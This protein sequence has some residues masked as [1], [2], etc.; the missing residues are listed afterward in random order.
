MEITNIYD[1]R[2]QAINEAEMK[3]RIAKRRLFEAERELDEI[4]VL[5]EE[6]LDENN[7]G[8]KLN[9]IKYIHKNMFTVIKKD[10]K[11]DTNTITLHNKNSQQY[12]V[13]DM[14]GNATNKNCVEF[15]TKE[16]AEKWA[17]KMVK[18]KKLYDGKY[19]IV[20][21]EEVQQKMKNY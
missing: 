18:N 3:V 9:E 2:L 20:D 16:E 6:E 10:F 15:K 21:D 12:V 8:Q 1:K 19:E 5:V 11:P 17:K 4:L 7:E 14:E 13:L